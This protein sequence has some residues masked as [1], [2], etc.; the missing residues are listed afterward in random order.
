MNY[1]KGFFSVVGLVKVRKISD[2][3]RC[4]ILDSM[5]KKTVIRVFFAGVETVT[6]KLLVRML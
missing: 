1:R 6:F 2:L 5:K 4:A 3:K